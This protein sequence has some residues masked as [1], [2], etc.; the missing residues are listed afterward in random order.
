ML[1]LQLF[2]LHIFLLHIRL[3]NILDVYNNPFCYIYFHY[4]Y[5]HYIS[6]PSLPIPSLTSDNTFL[7]FFFPYIMIFFFSHHVRLYISWPYISI[8]FSP[9]RLITRF[10]SLHHKVER[11]L[12]ESLVRSHIQGVRTRLCYVDY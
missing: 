1:L 10:P 3:S 4:I 12:E 5:C 8:R 6:F 7:L 9:L 2:L 11:Y